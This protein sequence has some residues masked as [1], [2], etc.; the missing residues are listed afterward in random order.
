MGPQEVMVLNDH[1][2]SQADDDLDQSLR[3]HWRE[4]NAQEEVSEAPQRGRDDEGKHQEIPLEPGAVQQ[5]GNQWTQE[6]HGGHKRDY[7]V[8]TH[9]S[10]Y[11]PDPRSF[12]R[13]CLSIVEHASSMKQLLLQR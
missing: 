3:V 6:G 9:L 2:D 11:L 13:I 1:E 5:K 7:S 8:S 12:K 4:L 10:E